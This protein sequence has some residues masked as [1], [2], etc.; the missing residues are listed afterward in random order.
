MMDE[1]KSQLIVVMTTVEDEAV[2]DSL[3]ESILEKSLAACIQILPPMRSIYRWENRIE[4][5]DENLLLIK[6]SSE[7]Y[8]ELEAFIS[9]VHLYD[10]PDVLAVEVLAVSEPYRQWLLSELS[11]NL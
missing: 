2:A 8:S 1:D 11:N 10:T 7:K 3:A 6:T 9:S 5:S 4:R